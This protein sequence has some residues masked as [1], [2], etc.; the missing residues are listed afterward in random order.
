[1]EKI[2]WYLLQKC[3]AWSRI[4]SWYVQ[5]KKQRKRILNWHSVWKKKFW[6]ALYNGVCLIFMWLL[7]NEQIFVTVHIIG[8]HTANRIGK[9]AIWHHNFQM[10]TQHKNGWNTLA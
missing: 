4:R 10:Q 8:I 9:N 7:L 3:L 1:L 5:G 6:V 2:Q